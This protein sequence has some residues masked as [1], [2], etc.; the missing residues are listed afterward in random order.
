MDEARSPWWERFFS[1]DNGLSWESLKTPDHPWADQ[2]IPWLD[3]AQSSNTNLPIVLP[4][5]DS[6]GQPSWYCGARSLR[7]ALQLREALQAFLG[8]SYTDFDGRAYTLDPTDVVENAFAECTEGPVFKIQA[9]Q[10]NQVPKIKRA[11]HIYYGLLERMPEERPYAKSPLRVLRAELDRAIAVGD[12]NNARAI[13]DR[14]R[15][16]G[17]LDAENLLYVDVE[18]RAGLG[19]W[20]DI[21]W[22]KPLLQKLTGLRLPPRILFH[23]HEALYRVHVEHLEDIKDPSAALNGFRAAKL[24]KWSALYGTRRGLNSPRLLKAFFLFELTRDKPEPTVL[25]GLSEEL[26]Q[27][28]EPFAKALL[29]FYCPDKPEQPVTSTMEDANEAFLNLELDRALDLYLNAP[30]SDKRLVQLIRCAEEIGTREAARRVIGSLSVDDTSPKSPH[31]AVKLEALRELCAEELR[32]SGVDGWLAWA[33]Q[34]GRGIT[35]DMAISIV[36]EN[37]NSW[38]SARFTDQKESIEEFVAIVNNADDEADLVFREATPIIYQSV[39]P[40][41]GFPSRFIKPLL[42]LLVTK[43]SLFTDPSKNE[44]QLVRDI[45]ETILIIGLD[46]HEYESLVADLDDLISNQMAP[47]VLGWSLDVAELL[48]LQSCPSPES[49]LRLVLKVIEGAKRNSHRLHPSDFY[50][51]EQLCKDV[52][53]ECPIQPSKADDDRT[54]G[55]EESLAGKKIAIYTLVE[56]AGQRAAAVL[57]KLCPSVEVEL[58][59][60]H[61]CTESLANLARSADLFVFAWKSSKHQA[62]F[63]IKKYRDSEKP[64]LQPLGK[65]ASSILRSVLEFS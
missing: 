26:K 32:S 45:A 38:D 2:V 36:R 64:L 59:Y 20:E 53:I 52:D 61:E 11:L 44:L 58:N 4:R 51:V 16:I 21:A 65:G 9:S 3:L 57:K 48:T 42:Q 34:V 55:F 35:S 54:V 49:R 31:I 50:I 39:V 24:P 40:E 18:L 10:P 12:E 33:R 17:R 25:A 6:Q 29:A 60:D 62:F 19:H 1:A 14:I 7:G 27:L 22:D 5:L 63:C 15:G 23:I 28:D 47:Q 30:P 41:Q 37:A 13:V 8:P 46:D 43:V 56:P